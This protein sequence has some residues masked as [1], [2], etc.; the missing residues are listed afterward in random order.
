VKLSDVSEFLR[1][2]H[3][4]EAFRSFGASD[5]RLS[6]VSAPLQKGLPK[7]R[8]LCDTGILSTP[9]HQRMRAVANF[10]DS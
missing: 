2:L 6:E 1:E 10:L 5:K 3:E 9:R 4:L 7:F 8:S